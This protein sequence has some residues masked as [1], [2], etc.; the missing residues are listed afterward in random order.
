MN[1]LPGPVPALSISDLTV[2]YDRV[3][4]VHH[5]TGRF[6]PGSLT[7][8]V[9]PNGAGKSTLL[10]SIA[11]LVPPS[12]G[13]ITLEGGG[14]DRIAYLP[15]LA[16]IDRSFPISVFDVVSLGLWREAGLFRA[17]TR[18][19]ERRARAAIA[20]VGLDGFERKQVGT[21]SAGQLQRALFARLM[22]QD[23]GLVLL[24]EPFAA[25]DERTAGDLLSLV[26]EWHR[27]G[28]TIIAVLHDIE[29]V[30]EA[31]PDTLLIAREP[32]AWGP[33]QEV[34]TPDNLRRARYISDSWT[35]AA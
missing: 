10:K 19:N 16:E 35:S 23:A 33:T 4:A 27:E 2:A 18:A 6:E 29:R 17:L 14:R 28:R 3:P 21:L 5:L 11:G 31:F 32:V 8:I 15:Q 22:L 34:L 30:R 24:D 9:G 20:A 12:E 1:A 7:A 25:V 26:A 13:R